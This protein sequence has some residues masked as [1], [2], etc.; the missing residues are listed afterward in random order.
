M[1]RIGLLGSK[2]STLDFLL[3]FEAVTGHAITHIALLPADNKAAEKVAYHMADRLIDAAAG[4]ALHQVKSYTLGHADDLAFFQE[5]SLDILFVIGWERLLPDAILE[6]VRC[7]SY[8]MHGSAYALPRGRGRSPMNWA[9]LEGKNHF[10]TS[11]FRYTPGI[12]DGDVVA[13]QTFTVFP[14]DDIGSLHTKNRVS[15]LRIAKFALPGILAGTLLHQPQTTELPTYYPKRTPDDGGIDWSLPSV[16]IIR[17]VRAV[18][19]P[20]PGAFTTL[21]DQSIKIMA[22]REF[23]RSM[24]SSAIAPG[25]IVDVSYSSDS[26]VVKTGDGSVLVTQWAAD[27]LPTLA[28]GQHL[29]SAAVALDHAELSRRYGDVP[30]SQWEIKPE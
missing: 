24:F 27:P 26:F 18:A 2:G 13:S 16:E 6:T 3:N 11:L 23:E 10:T 14:D 12:D 30:E 8:G 22:C 21:A 29:S 5:A 28:I 15:M 19:P 20:Y 17:L 7:G 1:T 4:R 25:E 9:I